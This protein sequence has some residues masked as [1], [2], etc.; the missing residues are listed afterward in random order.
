M[1]FRE[2]LN[3]MSIH[4]NLMTVCFAAVFALGLAACSSS[5]DGPPMTGDD[6][7]GM[8][9]PDP[10]IAQRADIKM[11]IDMAQ[12]AVN[13]V[14]NES[15]DAEVSAAEAAVMAAKM[16]IEAATAV[17]Q[18][19]RSAN[20]QAV[21][22]LET[23]LSG[24]KMA[25]MDAMD[26]ADKAEKMAM[27]ATAMKLQMG[28]GAP[29]DTRAAAYSG[30]DDANITVTMGTATQVLMEDKMA[31][32][33]ANHGWMGKKYTASGTDVSGT[34][35]AMV[36][37]NVG[38]PTPGKM[39]GSAAA[40][41]ESGDFQYQLTD[42]EL[43]IDTTAAGVAGR[44]ASSSFDQSAGTKTFELPANTVRV[45]VSGTHHGVSG[46]YNCTPA[47]NGT[48]CSATIAE[49]GFTLQGGTW[50]FKPTDPNARVTEMEDMH[51]ASYGW[52][53]H[54]SADGMTFTASAFVDD[55]GTVPAASG[56]DDLRGTAKY[57]GGA[58]GKYALYS[59]TGGTNDAG[60]FTAEAMLEADFNTD[61][62]SGTIDNF[63]GA[64]GMARDWSVELKKSGVNDTGTI[65]GE[66][67]TGDPMMTVWTIDGAAAA[68]AGQWSG[69]LKDNGTDGVP[70]V[71]T[72]TFY[73]MYS[74]AGKMVGGFGATRQ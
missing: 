70:K 68:A 65:L 17:P 39:F 41:T 63:M 74:T 9:M 19:E 44:V 67:G 72:G 22:A 62:I 23:Q 7:D 30:T 31:M 45:M 58:A 21:S 6:G 33:A 5:D 32:A 35:E 52:W 71:A 24:A 37:S 60:H 13:A 20:T 57:M 27:M 73:S 49:S 34:Y 42:G 3:I 29:S 56:I 59:S 46:T 40:V 8:E 4:R 18:N 47:G 16:A 43:A 48:N 25:R 53:I 14:D 51:Y 1:I 55:K 28:I 12:T 50:T 26:E 54:K 38:D 36:Y 61:M 15:T 66:D 11:K 10:A 69:M 64:D 2:S